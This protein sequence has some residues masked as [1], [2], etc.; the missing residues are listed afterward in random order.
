MT[1]KKLLALFGIIL[2]VVYVG[3]CTTSC[4]A[5]YNPTTMKGA[6][7]KSYGRC[8]VYPKYKHFRV[9]SKTANPKNCNFVYQ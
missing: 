8:P 7:Q 3:L 9:H 6:Y 2:M 1:Y 5:I 4:K